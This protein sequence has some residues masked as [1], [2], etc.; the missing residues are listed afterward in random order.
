[1]QDSKYYCIATYDFTGH[2]MH[3]IID[4]DWSK[5]HISD[6]TV[7]Y[8]DKVYQVNSPT[9]QIEKASKSYLWYDGLLT[10][11]MPEFVPKDEKKFIHW[12]ISSFRSINNMVAAGTEAE[13]K[14]N[15]FYIVPSPGSRKTQL[16]AQDEK[17]RI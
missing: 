14:G 3:D 13:R 12:Q 9:Q 11:T 15:W 1:M 7:T 2:R 17:H 5:C 4:H 6:R 8:N 10:N 16:I